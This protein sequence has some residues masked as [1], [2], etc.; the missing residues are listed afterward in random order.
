M[1]SSAITKEEAARHPEVVLDVLNFYTRQQM[2]QSDYPPKMTNVPERS[3]TT[4]TRFGGMGLAG[5]AQAAPRDPPAVQPVPQ[6]PADPVREEV[7]FIVISA[8]PVLAASA[9]NSHLI[10]SGSFGPASPARGGA[11]SSCA[12]RPAG[13][14]C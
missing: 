3:M 2:G 8:A 13:P 11:Q 5:Q 1:T 10:L 6:R 9:G 12:S 4:A 7:G 14:A